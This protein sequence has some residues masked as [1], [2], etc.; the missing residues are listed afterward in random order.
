MSIATV[1]LHKL[2]C[3]VFHGPQPGPN[4]VVNHI[5]NEGLDN[6]AKNLEWLPHGDNVREAHTN[7]LIDYAKLAKKQCK[8]VLQYSLDGTFIAEYPSI[9]DAS[10]ALEIAKALI[11]R[12]CSGKCKSAGKFI[13][14]FKPQE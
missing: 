4:Y 3:I 13:W 2:I 6:S 8:P 9:K 1:R 14:R 12:N 7:G 5:N 11:S 10:L